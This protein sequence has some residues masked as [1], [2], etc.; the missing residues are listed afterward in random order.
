ML[1]VVLH[2]L[3]NINQLCFT[4]FFFFLE[5]ITHQ[6]L[7]M[8]LLLPISTLGAI[9]YTQ[10]WDAVVLQEVNILKTCQDL[11][12]QGKFVIGLGVFWGAGGEDCI[13]LPSGHPL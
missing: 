2:Y 1:N 10:L 9:G 13:S 8:L 5:K 11:Q 4:F 7:F 12:F 3:S 6:E